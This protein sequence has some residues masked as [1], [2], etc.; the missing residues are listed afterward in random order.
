MSRDAELRSIIEKWETTHPENE[1]NPYAM[2]L[3]DRMNEL[4]GNAP[5]STTA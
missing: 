2:T 1:A 5:G 4:F 3:L